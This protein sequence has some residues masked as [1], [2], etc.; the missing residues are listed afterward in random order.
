M[1]TAK[2]ERKK[3]GWRENAESRWDLTTPGEANNYKGAE[4]QEER[5]NGFISFYL[6]GCVTCPRLAGASAGAALQLGGLCKPG[7]LPRLERRH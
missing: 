5:E 4:L 2:G 6:K 7:T 3:E 1:V